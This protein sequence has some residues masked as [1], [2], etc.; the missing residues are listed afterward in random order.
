MTNGK[1]A[2]TAKGKQV[3]KKTKDSS[4]KTAAQKRK[5]A[6][7][8]AAIHG[9]N[10]GAYGGHTDLITVNQRPPLDFLDP[11]EGLHVLIQA[12]VCRRKIL[13]EIYGNATPCKPWYLSNMENMA[14]IDTNSS[15]CSVL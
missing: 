15:I 5:E 9:V 3:V 1:H 6:K 12:T 8:Y 7:A 13:A 11:N 10:R 14:H 2:A 4:S